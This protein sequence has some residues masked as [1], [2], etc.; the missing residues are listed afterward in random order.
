LA[1]SSHAEHSTQGCGEALVPFHLP[2]GHPGTRGSWG[3]LATSLAPAGCPGQRPT[4]IAASLRAGESFLGL[5]SIYRN[6]G[7]RARILTRGFPAVK[8]GSTHDQPAAFGG[9]WVALSCLSIL[10]K[11]S[12]NIFPPL[13]GLGFELRAPCLQSD[14]LLLEP[15]L[16]STLLWLFLEMGS[17]EPFALTDFEPRS[18]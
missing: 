12:L 18:F 10:N 3:L 2:L 1:C 13:V 11:A 7:A 4:A 17:C 6:P 8:A 16:Q 5:N 15:H 9:V 14:V